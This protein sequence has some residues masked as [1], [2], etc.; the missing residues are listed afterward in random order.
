MKVHRLIRK[1]IFKLLFLLTDFSGSGQSQET[2]HAQLANSQDRTQ[3]LRTGD[4]GFMYH[5]ELFITGRMKEVMILRGK[6]IYPQDIESAIHLQFPQIR[7]GGIAA[8]SVEIAK[9]E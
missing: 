1:L 8:F 9:E 5:D 3:Y 2:F 6:N 4:L 7:P